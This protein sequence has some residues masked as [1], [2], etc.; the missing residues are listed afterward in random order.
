MERGDSLRASRVLTCGDLSTGSRTHS[1]K[2]TC[3]NGCKPSPLFRVR[4][5][6]DSEGRRSGTPP[7]AFYF[8]ATAYIDNPRL[9]L[10]IL[11]RSNHRL[12]AYSSDS[13]VNGEM[14]SLRRRVMVLWTF[15][16]VIQV[17]ES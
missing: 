14:W 13:R 9:T 10:P 4:T 16:A 2:V 15:S 7:S 3:G 11:Y 6:G 12:T 5:G 1:L 8:T 17:C